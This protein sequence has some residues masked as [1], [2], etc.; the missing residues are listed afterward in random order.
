MPRLE[1]EA[2]CAR[3]AWVQTARTKYSYKPV[4]YKNPFTI[5]PFSGT[6]VSFKSWRR[7][8][9]RPKITWAERIRGM[10]EETGLMEEDWNDRRKWRKKIV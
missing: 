9:G 3:Q 6:F 4:T 5:R 8:R 1:V 7:K 2:F 10:I